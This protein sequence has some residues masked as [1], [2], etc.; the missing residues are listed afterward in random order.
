MRNRLNAL[1]LATVGTAFWFGTPV[2]AQ[3]G[4][5]SEEVSLSPLNAVILGLVEGLTEYLPVS[6]TGHLLFTQELLGL[7][8]N[9][10][11]ESALDTYAIC[12]QIGAIFAVLL[13]YWSRIR[14]MLDGLLGRSDEGR[15]VLIA[16]IGAF[17]P[18]AIIGLSIAD[19]VQD[20]LFG[21]LPIS[22][23]WLVGGLIIL[24]LGRTSFMERDGLELGQITPKQAV[25]IGVCQAIALWPGV[26]RSWVT[27]V[28]G[29]AVGLS[30]AGAIEF[31]FLLGL[32]TLTAAT[33]L[34]GAKD[35]DEVIEL[36]GW[37]TP[38]IGM[39]VAFVSAV[40][41]VKWMVN[42]LQEKGLEIFGWYR[43]AIGIGGLVLI[44]L[45]VVE[46][47]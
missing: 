10:R 22:V 32:I 11:A 20:N 47:R 3:N 15:R 8:V 31:A 39:V 40:A 4:S 14:Q 45:G 41:A 16:V 6:S 37:T 43:V 35:G 30:L 7:N 19:P 23:A 29:L 46:P 44:A 27:I 18:T 33:V 26:S 42:W 36:F 24:F 38:L 34:A 25:I 21:A 12:I 9:D 2:L 1:L 5:G 13:L 17:I 28:A